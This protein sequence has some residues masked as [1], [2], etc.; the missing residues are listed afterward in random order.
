MADFTAIKGND[1]NVNGENLGTITIT[2]EEGYDISTC[3]IRITAQT[4]TDPNIV[5]IFND[6]PSKNYT[7]TL[8]YSAE[9]TKRMKSLSVLTVDLVDILGRFKTIGKLTLELKEFMND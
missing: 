8:N 5:K 7:I 9:E 2:P 4:I 3:S 1:T 6:L